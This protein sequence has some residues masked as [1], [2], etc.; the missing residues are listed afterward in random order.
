MARTTF[1]GFE[2]FKIKYFFRLLGSPVLFFILTT[3]N[4]FTHPYT[5]ALLDSKQIERPVSSDLPSL[6]KYRQKLSTNI[7][8]LSIANLFSNFDQAIE[9]EINTQQ[10]QLKDLNLLIKSITLA[11]GALEQLQNRSHSLAQWGQI[12]QQWQ[13][14]INILPK[15][16]F[17]PIAQIAQSRLK[18]YKVY[19]QQTK[20][21]QTSELDSLAFLQLAELTAKIAH[22]RG[23]N[24][25]SLSDWVIVCASWHSA[26][27]SLKQVT[28]DTTSFEKADQLRKS[29]QVDLSQANLKKEQQQKNQSFYQKAIFQANKAQ[30]YQQKQDWIQASQS[31]HYA[32]S[33]LEQITGN[34]SLDI[35]TNMS[36]YLVYLNVA[37]KKAQFQQELDNL[38]QG[39]ICSYNSHNQ[40]I[41]IFLDEGYIAKI[42]ELSEASEGDPKKQSE[43]LNHISALETG[44]KY[45]SFEMHQSIR[46]YVGKNKKILAATY[47]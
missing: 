21:R 27:D 42:R 7:A 6:V 20:T 45:L 19:Y 37:K 5:N 1:D 26:L 30:F 8:E 32:I 18:D 31:W 38:C 16:S 41:D 22:Q 35:Q 28:P 14:A 43:V 39:N 23:E 34:S 36:N 44:F 13:E 12:E 17:A 9:T 3:L 33:D 46:V 24:A 47:N 2:Q 29:Y 40:G 15:I 10:E 4:S 25:K 11:T